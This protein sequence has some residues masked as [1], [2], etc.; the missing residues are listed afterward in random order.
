[1]PEFLKVFQERKIDRVAAAYAVT[2]WLLVQGAAI[3][4]PTFGAPSWMMRALIV[5]A[6][7]GFPVTIAIAWLV[8]SRAARGAAAG[9]SSRTDMAL[10]ALLA[11]VI[12]ASAGQLIY[13]LVSRSSPAP[14]QQEAVA[15]N[16]PHT[17]R[18]IAVLP[19][20]NYSGDAT[21]DFF[22]DGMT[23]ELTTALARISSLRVIS[24]GS[25]MNFKGAHRP[26]TPD[27]A[28]LLHVDAVIEGSVMR[29][30]DRVRIT[31]QLIDAVADK[32]LWAKTFER[33]SHD[34][35][36]LQDEL[37]T[38]IATE[39]NVALTPGEKARLSNS[40]SVNPAAHD[41]Y[42]KGRYFFARPS[43]EN[44]K[45]SIAAFEDAIRLDPNF[46]PAYSG[47]ADALSWAGFNEGIMTSA[48]SYPKAVAA[49]E[50]AVALDD[51]SAEAHTSLANMAWWYD[52]DPAR[53][54]P[55]FQ[56][57]FALNPNYAY[58]H[59]QYG[60]VL[61]FQGQLDKA[62]AEGKR[63]MELDP[64]SPQVILDASFA[65]AWKG[66]ERGARD[67]VAKAASLDPD[68]FMVPF[69]YGWIDLQFG[70]AKVAVRE[71]E[72]ANSNGA[73]SFVGGW[74]ALAYG[75]SGDRVHATAMLDAMKKTEAVGYVAPLNLALAYLGLGDKTHAIDYLEK[76]Y[77]AKSQWLG[78]LNMDKEFDPLRGEPRFQALM[79]KLHLS[80]PDSALS[81][82]P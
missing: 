36:A 15:S 25:A 11:L 4:L 21:Q 56:K 66:D 13:G 68:F 14:A 55:E 60:G 26:P 5:M 82:Y 73:P 8:T 10:L 65:Y 39:V 20:D 42:L 81:I 72:K 52:Y 6:I 62:I 35:F 23:D 78:W 80:R 64:L 3:A 59:D 71:L 77:T 70:D 46:A 2:A 74:L 33:D 40:R 18:S 58:A 28:K 61:G 7:L 19:L 50:K 63:A 29:S 43:D 54:E 51:D 12:L 1:V 41:A 37:T 45:K 69:S 47:L 49:A 79:K 32:H 44:L 76:A 57:A 48:E 16:A 27:I 17:I 31:A 9:V 22:V 24:R 38:A 75:V 34:V 30:G 67:V 53:S